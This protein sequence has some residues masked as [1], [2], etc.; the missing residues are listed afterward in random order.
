[1]NVAYL[2]QGGSLRYTEP[3]APQLHIYHILRHLQE[4]GHQAA[5]MALSGRRV[6]Y[7]DELRAVWNG[8]LTDEH[9]AD[10]GLGGSHLYKGFESALRR[11]QV[12][13][14][15]PY[16]G[17]FDSYR[18]YEAACR[19]LTTTL[20]IHERYNLLA[21]A[22][23]L[24]SKR[25]S[26][27]Y[28]LE[29]NADLLDE[30]RFQGVPEEGLRKRYAQWT[31]RMSFTTASKLIAVS[32]Q[33]KEHL[34]R[35]WHVDA[36]KIVVLPNAADTSA[37]GRR[38]D[39]HSVKRQVLKLT[40]EPVIMFVGGFYPWHD[41]HLLLDSFSSVLAHIPQAR[42]VLVGDGRT[43][44]EIEKR[45]T[46]DKLERVVIMTGQIAHDRV[47]DLL[48]IADVAVAPTI[49]FFNGHGGSPLKL[50]EYMAASKSIVATRTGQVTEIIDD[51]RTGILVPPGDAAA[52]AR[53]IERLL[54]EPTLRARLG[55][56]ARK[57]AI[58]HHSWQQYARRL[59]EIY[60]SVA[61]SASRQLPHIPSLL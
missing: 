3:G 46:R 15:L 4:R 27:P 23:A 31:T 17:L 58:E 5:L 2:F 43:K 47:P 24:A 39:I 22:G 28:I 13:L 54:A 56:A 14:K 26:V 45:V 1:M 19:H 61:Q 38:V 9:F 11:T 25:L 37:F 12:E 59:E 48:A 57:Q 51:G 52:F 30:R 21:I 16:F 41:L 32:S 29:V 6:I 20:V 44:L 10:L 60:L 50:F 33:L 8:A 49:S 40:D 36:N 55:K 42:L 18:L 35:K 53:A 34:V 7:T